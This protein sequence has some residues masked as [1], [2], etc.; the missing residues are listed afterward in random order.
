MHCMLQCV[1]FALPRHATSRHTTTTNAC[2]PASLPPPTRCRLL[3]VV[4]HFRLLGRC[5]AKALQD[6]RLLDLP[7]SPLLYRLALG[8]SAVDLY[9]V[10]LL[11]AGLGELGS[12]CL[13]VHCSA[14]C[15]AVQPQLSLRWR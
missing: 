14:L 4:S 13:L 15:S 2:P 6:G 8:R 10:R 5:V 3:Q 12:A 7:L 11:D 9:D 1:S